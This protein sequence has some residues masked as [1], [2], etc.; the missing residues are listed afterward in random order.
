[1]IEL[2]LCKDCKHYRGERPKKYAKCHHP[3]QY[4]VSLVTGELTYQPEYSFCSTQRLT[5]VQSQCGPS[6]AWFEQTEYEPKGI[7]KR[8]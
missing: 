4:T 2:K 7:M 3:S 1:M 8:T 5:T 6:G